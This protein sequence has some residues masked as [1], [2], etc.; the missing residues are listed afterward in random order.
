MKNITLLMSLFLCSCA[1]T[2]INLKDQYTSSKKRSIKLPYQVFVKVDNQPSK[3]VGV[4][5]GGYGNETAGV[6]LPES[7]SAWLKKAV[8]K[9]FYAHG[10]TVN[11]KRSAKDI[12]VN[13]EIVQLFVEPDVG[14][15]ATEVVAVT[16]LKVKV[17]LPSKKV[18]QRNFIQVGSSAEMVWSDSD[19]T[20]RFYES[21]GM[22]LN[23]VVVRV[24]ELISTEKKTALK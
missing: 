19:I 12:K 7:Q 11:E 22:C 10:F 8:E 18:Y 21:V 9:E 14:F 15:W 2:N 17:I 6:Y 3:K 20:N 16:D 5:K 24:N 23:D 1:L 4:K 13:V